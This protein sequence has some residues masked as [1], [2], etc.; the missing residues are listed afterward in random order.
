MERSVTVR[1][2]GIP[3]NKEQGLMLHGTN[4]D[5][6][7]YYSAGVFNGDGQN[8]KNVDNNFDVMGRAWVAPLSFGGP[9]ELRQITVGGSL[10]TGD[11][12]NGLP[13]GSQSTQ[14]GY[15]ILSSGI[16]GMTS[17]MAAPTP[18]LHQQGRL[19]AWAVELNAPIAHKAGLRIEVV[20]KNQ[21]LSAVDIANAKAPVIL[22]GLH[23]K[24]WSAYG[25]IWY[26]AIGDDTIIG[27][28]GLQLPT[29]LK[30]FGSK[31]PQRGLMLAARVDRLDEKL[32]EDV[33]VAGLGLK[34]SGLGETKLTAL[35]L[36]AN[37]WVSR[38][39]RAT[40]NYVLN[41]FDGDT[42]YVTTTLKGNTTE[43]EFLFRLAIAL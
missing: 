41:H 12:T 42:S 8:Y 17:T 16:S 24:G 11:R 9:A 37:Y 10:W 1:A 7:F 28:P 15:G 5:R 40:F 18:E 2:F 27:E 38:R 14:G 29:R 26:W 4:P 30:K 20:G 22:E 33:V 39:F 25:E 3:S 23:L 13:L 19:K 32:T 36:G 43:Q 21:P 34:G 6:N 35:T 31:P